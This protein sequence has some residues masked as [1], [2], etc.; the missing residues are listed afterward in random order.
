MDV[1]QE[2]QPENRSSDGNTVSYRAIITAVVVLIL[3]LIGWFL[4]ANWYRDRLLAVERANVTAR[5]A[6]FRN[7]LMTSISR[8]QALLDGLKALAE[9]ERDP[10]GIERNFLPYAQN[11]VHDTSGIRALVSPLTLYIPLMLKRFGRQ[12]F[13]H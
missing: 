13:M 2:K 5:L 9:M 6:P 4:L 11:I 3:C 10:K 7:T 1:A 8:R 12:M